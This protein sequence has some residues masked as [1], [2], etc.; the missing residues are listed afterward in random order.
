MTK[1]NVVVTG[2]G[3]VSPL[4]LDVAGLWAGLM[5]GR[6]GT[7]PLVWKQ[8]PTLLAT[9]RDNLFDIVPDLILRAGPRIVEGTA[10]LCEK[11]ETARARRPAQ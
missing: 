6:S 8:Y 2:M 5:E 10:Q 3:A 7:G 4:G 1:R 11:L 9:K